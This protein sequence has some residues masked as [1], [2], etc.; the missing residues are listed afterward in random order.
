MAVTIVRPHEPWRSIAQ[1][2]DQT[3]PGSARRPLVSTGAPVQRVDVRVAAPDGAVGPIEF[4][5]PSQ[6]SRYIGAELSL[7]DDGYFVTGDIGLMD[8]G[9][10]FVM[11]RGDEAIV[12]AGRNVFPDDIES[13]GPARVH[14]AGLHRRR[15]GARRRPRGCR[16]AERDHVGRGA[17]NRVSRDSHGNGEPNRMVAGDGRVRAA[18]FVAE[19]PEREAPAAGDR[20][21][22]RRR[23]RSA[24]PGGLRMT[25]FADVDRISAL[26]KSELAAVTGEPIAAFRDD[27]LL[28]DVGLDS[29]SLIEALLSVREQI[30]EGLGLSVDDV[31]DPPTLPWMETVGELLAFV[32]SSVPT[33]LT[34]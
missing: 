14:S 17:R 32:R 12:V 13:R 20:S 4:R 8:D 28:S 6:L 1:P 16:G 24:G 7:T 15:R 10:L 3:F 5:S 31:S 9:E 34:G 11:G 27:A 29:L 30:L 26:L 33:D 22:A 23:R 19:D 25:S 2:A 21:V 18:R